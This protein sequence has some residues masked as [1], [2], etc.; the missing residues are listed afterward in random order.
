MVEVSFSSQLTGGEEE[1]RGPKEGWVSQRKFWPKYCNL[2]R[3]GGT[4]SVVGCKHG[5]G[6][7]TRAE[8]TG[9]EDAQT[10]SIVGRGIIRGVGP[11][12][13]GFNKQ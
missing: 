11:G 9:G 7:M 10:M 8:V 4:D 3:M 2:S 12:T 1:K 13:E 6:K 5:K